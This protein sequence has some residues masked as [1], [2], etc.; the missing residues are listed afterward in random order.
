MPSGVLWVASRIKQAG[1]TPEKFCAWYE[2]IHIR[3]VT[4]LSGIPRA[5]RYESVKPSPTPGALSDDALWLTVYEM[6]DINFRETKEFRS[7]DGQSEPEKELLETVFKQAGFD[8]RFYECYFGRRIPDTTTSSGSGSLIIPAALTPAAGTDAGFDAWYREEHLSLIGTCPGYRRTR[9][10]KV[11][12][13]TVLDEFERIEPQV[14]TWLVIREFDGEKLPM[15]D[16]EKA[17]ETEWGRKI[18]AGLQ[19]AEGRVH[20]AEN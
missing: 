18:I 10:F 1:L 8:T 15:V 11:I 14:S 19:M 20:L 12:N 3:E 13:A 17:D 5:A 2:N 4:A 9:C 6:P 16:L 7:L